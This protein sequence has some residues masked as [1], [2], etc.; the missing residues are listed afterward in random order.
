MEG[1]SPSAV[2]GLVARARFRLRAAALLEGFAAPAAA[3][4][5]VLSATAAAARLG[6]R[7]DLPAGFL[8]GI[9]ALAAAAGLAR[10]L[11]GWA[12]TA[13]AA[14]HLDRAL[15]ARERFSTVVE[16]ARSDPAIAAWAAR[17]ALDRAGDGAVE[18]ALALRPPA[19][20]VPLLL[21]AVLAAGLALLPP[22]AAGGGEAGGEGAPGGA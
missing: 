21:A 8:G 14:L 2:L 19:A 17:G 4:L 20:L 22:E 3:F 16:T 7:T 10:T 13:G 9:G 5:L 11:R 18:E 15:D 1:S 6:G 12:G